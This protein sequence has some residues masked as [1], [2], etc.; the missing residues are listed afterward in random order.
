MFVDETRPRL[1]GARLTA[2]EL[3]NEDIP[4]TLIADNAAG[5]FM[6]RGDVDLVIVGADR[7]T[8]NGDVANKI[9]TYTKAVLAKE[10][11]IPFYVAGPIS[12][13]DFSLEDGKDI[14]IEERGQEEV[15]NFFQQKIAPENTGARNPAF[16]V[17][18]AKYVTGIITERGIFR[19]LRTKEVNDVPQNN[20][21]SATS[22]TSWL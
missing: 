17:T 1:Q 16:D 14:P 18:P 11:D 21:F 9:G 22:G 8:R 6:Q 12:T 19:P 3:E 13:F 15:L 7:I 2:W 4:H 5:H 10:N 20:H